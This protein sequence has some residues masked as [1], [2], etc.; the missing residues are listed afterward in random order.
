MCTSIKITAENGNVFWGRTMDMNLPMFGE[1]SSFNGHTVIANYPSNIEVSSPL[2]KWT[3]KYSAIGA[4][5]LDTTMLYDGI[6]EFGLAGD[7]QV[8]TEAVYASSEEVEKSGLQGV[9]AEEFVT[10]ILTNYKTVAE[11]EADYK[12]F[13]LL[14]MSFEV[15]GRMFNLP[16][17]FCFVDPTGDGIVLESTI[18]GT[19]T[20]YEY[21]GVMT[22][23]P[24]YPYHVTNIRN[25][26]GL[27]SIDLTSPKLTVGGYE[28]EP[29]EN[30]TG[31]SLLGLPGDYTS[32]SRFVRS[33]YTRDLIYGFER[34]QGINRL[35][36]VFRTVIVPAGLEVPKVGS[37]ISDFTRYWSGYDLEKKEMFIQ[38]C[39]GLGI[40]SKTLDTSLTEI[41]FQEVDLSNNPCVLE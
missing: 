6:N 22:N 17:H 19:L 13:I 29:I 26:I 8:L 1:D 15:Q 35:Y 7:L 12:K 33:F 3:T 11:I 10:Y 2:R 28:V 40:T 36:G 18:D 27:N 9:L 32:P 5:A 31:Y 38:S 34:D 21:I 37:A 41:T 20:C 23:S 16:L 4:G 24:T 14:D 39:L 25:Y 30:G